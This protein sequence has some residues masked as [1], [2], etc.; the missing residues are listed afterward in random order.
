M[1]TH[2]QYPYW[3]VRWST[4]PSIGIVSTHLTRCDL[5]DPIHSSFVISV[6]SFEY[7]S[8]PYLSTIFTDTVY[9]ILIIGEISPDILR[10]IISYQVMSLRHL[11]SISFIHDREIWTSGVDYFLHKMLSQRAPT[12]FS[13]STTRE[14]PLLRMQLVYKSLRFLDS[15]PI[16]SHYLSD[17]KI[18]LH[19][20]I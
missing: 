16:F 4:V 5:P 15:F 2:R 18:S 9:I 14:K 20:F 7:R 10:S 17:T 19:S 3:R 8:D 1:S 13:M 11:P 6:R 12:T